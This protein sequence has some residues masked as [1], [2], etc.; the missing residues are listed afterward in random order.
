MCVCLCVCVCV[1]DFAL[2]VSEPSQ[3]LENDFWHEA[4]AKSEQWQGGKGIAEMECRGAGAVFGSGV[5]LKLDWE[6]ANG[7]SKTHS[8]G[9]F[10]FAPWRHR[11]L[12][13][14]IDSD[15]FPVAVAL[16]SAQSTGVAARWRP[17]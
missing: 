8:T 17:H 14:Q 12:C 10:G 11:Q 3:L 16:A 6:A 1:C 7:Q 13:R 9:N 4:A 5:Q 2:V 15:A